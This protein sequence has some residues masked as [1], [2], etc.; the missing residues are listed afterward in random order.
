MNGLR[1]LQLYPAK[2][3]LRRPSETVRHEATWL[4][5][6]DNEGT[7]PE[8]IMER[9]KEI[10]VKL[11]DAIRSSEKVKLVVGDAQAMR[12]AELTLSRSIGLDGIQ[13]VKIPAQDVW[14]RDY[15]PMF[16]TGRRGLGGVKFAFNA[17]GG[18]YPELMADDLTGLRVLEMVADIC[19]LS[20]YVIEGG[21]VEIGPNGE[22][23]ATKECVLDVKRNGRTTR[24]AMESALRNYLGVNRVFWLSKGIVGDDTRG[25]VDTFVRFGEGGVVLIGEDQSGGPNAE[26]LKASR[27]ELEEQLR[28]SGS[29]LE[30]VGVPMPSEVRVLGEPVPA[31][32]LNFYVTNGSVIVPVF[33]KE[34]DDASASAIAE[35]F[36]GRKLITIRADELFYGLGGFH[37]VTLDEPSRP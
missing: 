36:R 34:T 35:A 20:N 28:A 17:W 7:F 33:G 29:S 18:L 37:C 23:I 2:L 26:R 5:W 9:V 16:L 12:D 21:M 15:G 25:H 10:Y 1:S 11:I 24:R 30:V 8:P 32:Y 6:P 22:A 14:I 13:L 27:R 19:F 3:G 4:V 31:T